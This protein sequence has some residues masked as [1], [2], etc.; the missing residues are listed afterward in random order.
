MWFS[1]VRKGNLAGALESEATR[2]SISFSFLFF[3]KALFLIWVSHDI[4]SVETAHISFLSQGVLLR[5]TQIQC[6]VTAEWM[7]PLQP[8]RTSFAVLHNGKRPGEII[9]IIMMRSE[10]RFFYGWHY[11]AANNHPDSLLSPIRAGSHVYLQSEEVWGYS[12]L[13]TK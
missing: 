13:Q 7:I 11:H 2:R 9:T 3:L 8:V 12:V 10:I 4:R 1:F 6:K 5:F